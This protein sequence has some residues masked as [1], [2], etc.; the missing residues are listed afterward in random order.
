MK[1]IYLSA[2]NFNSLHRDPCGAKSQRV[3]TKEFRGL[4]INLGEAKKSLIYKYKSPK[5][6]KFRIIVLDSFNYEQQL[7]EDQIDQLV[8]LHYD[9]KTKVRAGIDP[10]DEKEQ[11]RAAVKLE[12]EAA[13]QGKGS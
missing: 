4:G 6:D 2:K 13:G 9:I 5:T 11:A 7:D 12:Q 3:W 1:K 8:A 10:L